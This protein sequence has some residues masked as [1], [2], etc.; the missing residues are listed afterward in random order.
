MPDALS[1][2]IPIWVTVLNRLL[3]PEAPQSHVLQTPKDVVSGSEHAQIEA[4]VETFVTQMRGLQLQINDMRSKLRQRWM[5][6]VWQ[7]PGDSILGTPKPGPT[8]SNTVVLCTASNRVSTESYANSEYVQGAADDHES[9]ALGLDAS[10][11]WSHLDQL[12]TATNDELPS[13]IDSLCVDGLNQSSSSGSPVSI[14]PGG[15]IWI[16]S[17][18]AAREHMAEFDFIISCAA[19]PDPDINAQLGKRYIVLP[20]PEGK[21]GSRH[22][23]TELD[24]ILPVGSMMHDFDRSKKP[25]LLVTNEGSNDL[26]VGVALAFICCFCTEDGAF[27]PEIRSAGPPINKTIIKQRLSWIM[28][29]APYA[30]PSRATLQSVNAFLMG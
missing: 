18:A 1:K 28:I 8:G 27:N 9:W 20:C 17:N 4:K 19:E 2:T 30:K 22:L 26:A 11:F 29:S 7:R 6:I 21:V 23:R 12:L 24:K 25:H 3:F 16:A 5:R 10:T 15:F 14:R 13:L